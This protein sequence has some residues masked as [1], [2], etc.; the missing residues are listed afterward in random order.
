ML[1][2]LNASPASRS[3]GTPDAAQFR[4]FPVD[5]QI[6]HRDRI[7]STAVA[8]QVALLVQAELV[9]RFGYSRARRYQSLHVAA[10]AI[11]HLI[12]EIF[13]QLAFRDVRALLVLVLSKF[14]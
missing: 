7:V 11:A 9:S 4:R 13:C 6:R 12:G 10:P 5:W 14:T 3:I 1:S 2:G 8:F